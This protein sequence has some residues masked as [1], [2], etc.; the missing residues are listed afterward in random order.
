LSSK[1]SSEFYLVSPGTNS[2]LFQEIG[3]DQSTWIT[4]KQFK[5]GLTTVSLDFEEGKFYN[6][7]SKGGK[8]GAVNYYLEEWKDKDVEV[9]K[10]MEDGVPKFDT[11]SQIETIKAFEAYTAEH[12]NR[13]DGTWNGRGGTVWA[14]YSSIQY[15]FDEN[16]IK[17]EVATK[18][19]GGL[20]L[21][22]EAHILYNEDILV[23]LPE[24]ISDESGKEVDYISMKPYICYYILNGN[25][26]NIEAVDRDYL[27]GLWR[28]G[29]KF[30]RNIS[31]E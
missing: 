4:K 25:E 10:K 16:K 20:A 13:F 15:T 8:N 5:N 27:P 7:R 26:L 14:K 30:V 22:V 2:F 11:E 3:N 29:G 24:K 18:Q 31:V 17:Y 12:P 9:L 21:T 23:I 19:Y 6:L 28:V 1:P